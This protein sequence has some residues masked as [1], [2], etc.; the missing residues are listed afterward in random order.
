MEEAEEV[1]R[2]AE[3]AD[4]WELAAWRL[5]KKKDRTGG[6]AAQAMRS[7]TRK[8]SPFFEGVSPARTI[9]WGTSISWAVWFS[10]WSAF[11]QLLMPLKS[12]GSMS[13]GRT[14]HL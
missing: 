1:Q 10:A 8:E 14:H 9:G 2:E 3:D 12:S 6:A 4:L 7:L 13:S 5:A 11:L